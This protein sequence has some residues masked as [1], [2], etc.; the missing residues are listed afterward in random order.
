MKQQNAS[1]LQASSGRC[2]AAPTAQA[3]LHR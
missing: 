3:K 1:M 2:S